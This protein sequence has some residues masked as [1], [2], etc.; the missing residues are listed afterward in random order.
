[1][2]KCLLFLIIF[3]T[4]CSVNYNLVI[5]DNNILEDVNISAFDDISSSDIDNQLS[6][7]RYVYDGKKDVYD[8]KHKDN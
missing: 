7:K 3:L 1:M 2:K 5:D 4:G 6:Y 8:V